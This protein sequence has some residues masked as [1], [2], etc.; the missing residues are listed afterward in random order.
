MKNNLNITLFHNH[1]NNN[2]HCMLTV[3]CSSSNISGA[4][5]PSVPAAPD[6]RENDIRPAANFLQRPKSDIMTRI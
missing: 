4:I 3:L 5:H 1:Y 2:D 6:L